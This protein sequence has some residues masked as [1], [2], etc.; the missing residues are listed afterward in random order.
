MEFN[1]FRHEQIDEVKLNGCSDSEWLYSEW[2]YPECLDPIE[3][4][5]ITEYNS[6]RC[7]SGIQNKI[8]V[9]HNHIFITSHLMDVKRGAHEQNQIK[10]KA[11][12]KI[13]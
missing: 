3:T 11:K 12:Q 8:S 1:N 2:L 4:V 10:V 9:N 6:I 7:S 13:H 5:R